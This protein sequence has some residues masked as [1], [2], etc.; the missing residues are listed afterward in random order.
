MAEL[1]TT[2]KALIEEAL[3]E[4][5]VN[6]RSVRFSDLPF[7]SPGQNVV[8][9]GA[10]GIGSWL[11]TL[12]SRQECNL[13]VYDFDNIE[14]H[15]LGG[16]L[17]STKQIGKTKTAA[18]KE[19]CTN[20]SDIAVFEEMGKFTKD[21]AVDSITFSCFDNMAARKLMFE[22]WCAIKDPNKIFIDGRMLAEAAQLYCVI[23]GREEEYKA[24]LFEDSDVEEQPC[25]AK[26][27]SHCGAIL[28]GL[29]VSVFNNAITNQKDPAACRYTPFKLTYELQL[30]NFE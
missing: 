28:A 15:N 2:E 8:V 4:K 29:M 5:E 17:F 7:Y 1:T 22:K 25:T 3:A 14:T 19:N 23:P 10:G 24:T 6:Q 16:Q 12:L 13:Y 9:G 26:A 30:L 11:C 27:T 18:L 21:S 20:F